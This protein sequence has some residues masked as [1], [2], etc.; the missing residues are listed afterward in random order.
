MEEM[1]KTEL[2]QALRA[3]RWNRQAAADALGI[4]RTT[5][6]RKIRKFQIAS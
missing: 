3:H 2:L 4:S 5:L 1:E 6:W